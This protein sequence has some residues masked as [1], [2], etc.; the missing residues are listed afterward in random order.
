MDLK[1]TYSKMSPLEGFSDASY[2]PNTIDRK[3]ISGFVFMMNGGPI[4]WRS[5]K[6]NVVA[7]S[8]MESEYIALGDA[9]KEVLWLKKLVVD[10]KLDSK[11][12]IIWEDNQSTIKFAQHCIHSDRSKHIDV[13]FHFISQNLRLKQFMLEYCPTQ[14]MVADIFT[15]ALGKVLHFKHLTAMGFN[16]VIMGGC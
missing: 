16:A 1:L 7:T 8:S 3:S 11:N 10:F 6:Q 15:K 5:K 4:S 9:V 12:L 2:A 13:R 14:S